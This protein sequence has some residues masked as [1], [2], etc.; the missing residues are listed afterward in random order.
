[1][2]LNG[3]GH[4]MTG[5]LMINMEGGRMDAKSVL[6][7]VLVNICIQ[8]YDICSDMQFVVYVIPWQIL[9]HNG[10]IMMFTKMSLG[11]G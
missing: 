9:F 3:S 11:Y 7:H 4:P 6:K 10:G 5:F 8:Y 2:C 1:M